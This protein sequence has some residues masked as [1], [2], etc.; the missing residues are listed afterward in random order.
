MTWLVA[1]G[2][3]P[4]ALWLYL[5]AARGG[6][7]LPRNATIVMSPKTRQRGHPSWPLFPRAMNPM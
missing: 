6:Y 7:W 2:L 3:L 5:L 4:L 1:F